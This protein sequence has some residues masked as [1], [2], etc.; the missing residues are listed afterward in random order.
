MTRCAVLGSPIAHSLSPAM[1]RAAYAALGL[2]WTYDA[3]EVEEAALP[4]FV[5]SLGPDV[6]G[7]SLTMPLKRIA[8][9]L[10]D[11]VDPVAELIGAANTMLF[12]PDGSRSVHNTDVPGLVNAFAEQGITA[13]ET[14]V[15]LGG[16]ATAA[17]TLAALRG[18]GVS[19]VTV[20]VRDVA[21]AERLRDLAAELGLRTSVAD[22]SQVEQIGGFDLCVSTLPGGAVD[23]WAEHFAGVAPVVFDVAYHPWPTR[24]AIA[25]HR[26]GTELLNG[27]DL[28]V[29]QATL[30]VEMMTGRS[31]APLAAMRTAAREELGDREPA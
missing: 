13:A 2:D 17:S 10:A 21:K 30:Q 23:P 18:M 8:L 24:L 1:H 31:P 22:F 19:E 14:A 15:V 27:L 9:D 16:G 4:A 28:L 5:A 20:V 3:F 7:L 25:A 29:H 11:T 6:R 12:E 26:I